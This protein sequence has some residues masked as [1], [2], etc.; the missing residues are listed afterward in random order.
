M[1]N[2]LFPEKRW[3][4]NRTRSGRRTY[5]HTYTT[6]YKFQQSSLSSN[7]AASTGRCFCFL[8]EK[9]KK[10]NLLQKREIG[11]RE[12]KREIGRRQ[13]LHGLFRGKDQKGLD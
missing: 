9:N 12:K 3:K 11:G 10:K 5:V 8:G 13:G 1:T 4:E 6:L 7:T 2:F